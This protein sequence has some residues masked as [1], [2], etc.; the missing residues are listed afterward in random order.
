MGGALL[1][2]NISSTSEVLQTVYSVDL[3]IAF[4]LLIYIMI[5][6]VKIENNICVIKLALTHL[7]GQKIHILFVTSLRGIE[8]LNQRQ[9]LQ[10]VQT[11]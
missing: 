9:G 5:H 8:Q 1:K 7:L 11:M 10:T 4:L 2:F 6:K 3:E